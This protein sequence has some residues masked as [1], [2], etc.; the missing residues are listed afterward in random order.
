[1][2]ADSTQLTDGVSLR[3]TLPALYFSVLRQIIFVSEDGGQEGLPRALVSVLMPLIN[4]LID[5]HKSQ[6]DLNDEPSSIGLSFT[7]VSPPFVA[8]HGPAQ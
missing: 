3:R 7:A 1:M 2:V 6:T 5:C 4:C 8:L